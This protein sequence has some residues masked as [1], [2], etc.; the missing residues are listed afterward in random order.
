MNRLRTREKF[1]IGVTHGGGEGG[2][3]DRGASEPELA[4]KACVLG[5]RSSSHV[6]V[7]EHCCVPSFRSSPRSAVP[8]EVLSAIEKSNN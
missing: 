4:R 5:N 7:A 3:A 2:K 6:D 1:N 8:P